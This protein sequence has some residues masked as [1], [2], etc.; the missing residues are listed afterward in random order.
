MRFFLV[1]LFILMVPAVCLAADK[2][3]T[4]G[5]GYLA[6]ANG[7]KIYKESAG[8]A[9]AI[10]VDRDFPMVAYESKNEWLGVMAAES[11]A[12][13]R[14]HV[15]YF[16]NG[17]NDREG[18]NFAWV[19]LRDVE[20]IQFDCCGDSAHCSGIQDPL[21]KPASFT[22]C[23]TRVLELRAAKAAPKAEASA[24]DLELKKL[25]IEKLKL[26]LEIEKLKLEQ[27]RLRA[28]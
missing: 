26:Q 8:D 5:V 23:F 15:R 9:V 24:T 19:D 14:A 25:E 22:E 6:K 2:D 1:A 17:E 11:V 18:M 28:K 10:T 13:G 3:E 12:N 7:T 4:M 27:E 21:F 20:R 16:V